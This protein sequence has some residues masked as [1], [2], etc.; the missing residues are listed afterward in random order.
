VLT[1]S[2]GGIAWF[3]F[4]AGAVLVLL[5]LIPLAYDASKAYR[6]Q[7]EEFLRLAGDAAKGQG[8]LT[9]DELKE[10]ASILTQ[11][12]TGTRGLGRVLMAFMITSIIGFISLAL[13]FGPTS[14]DLLKQVVT[15]LLGVLATIVGFYF[16]SRTAET[17]A[18]AAAAEAAGDSKDGPPKNTPPTEDPPVLSTGGPERPTVTLLDPEEAFGLVRLRGSVNPQGETAF[19]RFEFGTT[20]EYGGESGGEVGPTSQSKEVSTEPFIPAEPFHYRL[21][22]WNDSGIDATDDHGWPE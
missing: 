13:L 11:P 1:F 7:H 2:N 12:L 14:A 19:Y 9:I 10:L 5:W 4:L 17:A 16:G 15:A 20:I 21:I 18:S 3:L 22:A 6:N 8:G